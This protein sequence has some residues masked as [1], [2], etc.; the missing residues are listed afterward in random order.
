MTVEYRFQVLNR[1]A[2]SAA[3][4]PAMPPTPRGSTCGPPGLPARPARPN[5]NPLVRIVEGRL[6]LTRDATVANQSRGHAAVDDTNECGR[7][8]HD[9]GERTSLRTTLNAQRL[10]GLAARRKGVRSSA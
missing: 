7:V 6:D 8:D 10:A 4:G 2:P 5:S 1:H 3:T 9:D